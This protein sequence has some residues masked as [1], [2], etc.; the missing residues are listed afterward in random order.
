MSSRSAASDAPSRE[1]P[2]R[3]TW[4]V[5][6]VALGARV[7]AIVA[8][9]SIDAVSKGPWEFGFEAASI[10]DS[11][12]DGRGF[13]S[14]WHRDLA[15]WNVDSG[16]TGWLSPAYPALLARLMDLFG[17]LVPATALAL[18]SIQALVSSAT[19][20][21]VWM[22]GAELGAPRAGK[23]AAWT[24][25][26]LPGAIWT[27]ANYVWDTSFVAFGVTAFLWSTLRFAR[28]NGLVWAVHGAGFGALL[29]VNPAPLAILPAAWYGAWSRR[30]EDGGAWTTHARTFASH[31]VV[32]SAVAFAVVSPWLLRNQR[33]FGSMSLRTNLGVEL[34]V[35]NDD[36]STGRYQV[37]V[38]PSNDAA[39][40][41]RYLELGEAAYCARAGDEARAWIREHPAR[42]AT[43]SLRRARL[44]WVGVD[45][46]NEDRSSDTGT[47]AVSDPK[48]WIKFLAYA[49]V[50]VLSL[51]GGIVWA[52]RGAA[53]RVVLLVILL[54]PPT[55]YVTHVSERYRMPIEPVLVLA[56][57]KF[58]TDRFAGRSRD[59]VSS[60]A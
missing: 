37:R 9:H 22:L 48:S 35:G 36:L 8:L 13:S 53:G 24:F 4:L 31:A 16:P 52:R 3:A 59:S 50:G 55:Y 54:F 17:G 39:Q 28:A 11:L 56:A 42:F 25:A 27:S 33:A 21:L 58:V 26:L 12:H 18:F 38:H 2:W 23:L 40:F 60:A 29:L 43:L 5:F 6:A 30:R 14:P 57:A 34:R 44:F 32:F 7:L 45:P 49:A 51:V 41:R 47:R 46:W 10:A 19:C 20:V 1:L 15:P